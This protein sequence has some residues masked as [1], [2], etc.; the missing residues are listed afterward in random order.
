MQLS[1]SRK[2][3]LLNLGRNAEADLVRRISQLN[4]SAGYDIE[5]FNGDFLSVIFDRFI[6]VKASI[7]NELKFFW[8]INEYEVAK[9][10]G[11]NYWIYFVGG[12]NDKSQSNVKPILIQNPAEKLYE[13]SQIKIEPTK[14]MISQ[15][16]NLPIEEITSDGLKWY[17]LKSNFN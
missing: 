3:R 7:Y 17:I 16:Q 1:C 14:F 13:I 9:E 5:S 12:F 4:V 10:K 11:D 6:E 2:K 8:T 15:I